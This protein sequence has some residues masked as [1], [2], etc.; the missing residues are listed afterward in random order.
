M[1]NIKIYS[2][3]LIKISLII[4]FYYFSC[5]PA[6]PETSIPEPLNLDNLYAA[7]WNPR[8]KPGRRPITRYDEIRTDLLSVGYFLPDYHFETENPDSSNSNNI[9]K[10]YG[11]N[12]SA[13]YK[14]SYLLLGLS[15]EYS[16]FKT[17]YSGSR[18]D[19][20]PVN[21][22]SGRLDNKLFRFHYT[23]G[24]SYVFSERVHLVFPYTGLVYYKTNT[25]GELA[26]DRVDIMYE[27]FNIPA[28]FRIF[29]QVFRNFIFGIDVSYNI[30]MNPRAQVYTSR[31]L[32]GTYPGIRED[33][34]FYLDKGWRNFRAQ[35]PLEYYLAKNIGITVTPWYETMEFG[36]PKSV[37]VPV[38]Y[39]IDN[40]PT[41]YTPVTVSIK[42]FRSYGC[43]FAV[44]VYLDF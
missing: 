39:D 35:A 24:F 25:R 38:T 27:W 23:V 20:L 15:F 37:N 6:F 41:S 4:I 16:N 44:N 12:A 17:D 11:I 9:K 29:F 28:G 32:S 5:I 13:H 14:V 22:Y 18:P 1:K 31:T 40:N 30:L 36:R 34:S 21:T 7:A 33:A 2:P 8:G 42:H 43:L 19:T 26:T 3:D 10:S